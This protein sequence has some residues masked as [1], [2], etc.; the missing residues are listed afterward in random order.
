LLQAGILPYYLHQLD[1]VQGAA[2]FE[3]GDGTARTLMDTLHAR[4]PGYL[5]PRL[6]RELPGQP[7]KS[8]LWPQL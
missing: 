8:P 1:R 7:G 3:V 2:H 5:V 6:V 4:L